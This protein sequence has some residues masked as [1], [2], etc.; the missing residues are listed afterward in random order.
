MF[1]PFRGCWQR[2]GL[3]VEP[4]TFSPEA[5]QDHAMLIRPRT[6]HPATTPNLAQDLL[7]RRRDPT[8]F[9]LGPPALLTA[10]KAAEADANKLFREAS[11]VM[12]SDPDQPLLFPSPEA[13]ITVAAAL[14]GGSIGAQHLAGFVANSS[15]G[16]PPTNHHDEQLELGPS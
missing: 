15:G 11:D 13:A 2:A 3:S 8:T 4:G 7:R 10:G 5:R 1:P 12:T 16:A 14:L 6:A 9:H